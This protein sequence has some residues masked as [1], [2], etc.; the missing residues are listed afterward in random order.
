M[1]IKIQNY[2][3]NCT[4]LIFSAQCTLHMNKFIIST[5]VPLSKIKFILLDLAPREMFNFAISIYNTKDILLFVG[6]LQVFL[7]T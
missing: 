5:I 3:C 7:Y 2:C 4:V 1:V 6:D